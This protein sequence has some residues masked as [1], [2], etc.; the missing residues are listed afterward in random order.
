MEEQKMKTKLIAAFIAMLVIVGGYFSYLKYEDYKFKES[1]T[2]HVK[3][4]SL[5]ITNEIHSLLDKESKMTYAEVFQKLESD[6]SE[7]DKN[8]LE[9]QSVSNS[10]TKSKSDPVIAYLQGGQEILRATLS[11]YRKRLA[12]SSASERTDDAIK[13]IKESTESYELKF[14]SKRAD[15]A[16]AEMTKA[17]DESTKANSDLLES[18]KKMETLRSKAALV[19]GEDA[20]VSVADFKSVVKNYEEMK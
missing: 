15:E 11:M 7:I 3:N 8:I 1:I 14:A 18:A 13:D 19:I 5:R 2:P 9:I 6:I 17:G 12:F 10:N 16:L 20:L 4:S